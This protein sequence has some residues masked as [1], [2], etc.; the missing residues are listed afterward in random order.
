MSELSLILY[1]R[2][3]FPFISLLKIRQSWITSTN[4]KPLC[5]IAFENVSTMCGMSRAFVRATK[6]AFDARAN[7]NGL[8]GLSWTPKGEVFEI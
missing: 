7:F 5:L 2:E 3:S 8:N 6:V 4:E 1:I